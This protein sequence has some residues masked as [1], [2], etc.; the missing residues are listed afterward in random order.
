MNLQNLL[1]NE[2]LMNTLFS[3]DLNVSIDN[4]TIAITAHL[5]DNNGQPQ[6]LPAA[7]VNS[8]D[9]NTFRKFMAEQ[10]LYVYPT[11]E[12]CEW[13][14]ENVIKVFG[15]NNIIEIGA[16]NGVLSKA[17]GVRATDNYSQ[18]SDYKPVSKYRELWE[19]G[20]ESMAL[21]G[22]KPVNYGE[23]VFRI[24][25]IEAVKRFKPTCVIGCFITDM[26]RQ[27]HHDRG[28][29]VFGVDEVKMK[30]RVNQYVM[31]GN[32]KTHA[33]KLMLDGDHE[34]LKIPG[35]ITRAEFPEL[36]RIFVW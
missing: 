4:D 32:L 1:S 7:F 8:F 36:D 31:V 10:G 34:E 6:V 2:V 29:N 35:I 18:A 28:G 3:G 25:A 11:E 23:N 16:G 33:K 5:L 19:Q 21:T 14:R 27:E 9:R 15:P 22:N 24:E 17:L 30:K 20:R 26:Y 13:M 12:L